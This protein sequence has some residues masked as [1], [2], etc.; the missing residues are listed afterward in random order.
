MNLAH[1][2]AVACVKRFVCVRSVKVNGEATQLGQPFEPDAVPAP[3][4]A[5]GVSKMQAEQGLREI[6]A[7]T[8]MEVVI[9]RPPLVYGPGVKANF[10]SMMRWLQRGV[11]FPFG[12]L[13]NQRSL[14]SLGNLVVLS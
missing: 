3:L 5:Y 14:V 7:Q 10:A 1:Q 4:D 12:A 2:A 13:H 9:I 8:G 6:S 11:P